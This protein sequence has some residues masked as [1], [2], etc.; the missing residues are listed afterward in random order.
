MGIK[1]K[2]FAVARSGKYKMKI[3][4]VDEHGIVVQ[5]LRGYDQN[6]MVCEGYSFYEKI[7]NKEEFNALRWAICEDNVDFIFSDLNCLIGQEFVKFVCLEQRLNK[8]NDSVYFGNGIDW[9]NYLGT[10]TI[11]PTLDCFMLK[12]GYV[13]KWLDDTILKDVTTEEQ[14]EMYSTLKLKYPAHEIH[15]E[16]PVFMSETI[17]QRADIIDY[18]TQSIFEIDGGQHESNIVFVE[19]DMRKRFNARKNGFTIFHCPNTN[20]KHI[21]NLL[22]HD[23]YDVAFDELK[24][25]NQKLMQNQVKLLASGFYE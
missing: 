13:N 5:I 16:A 2:K 19:N 11:M 21:V 24:A 4:D 12:Y 7:N 17:P 6:T 18:T 23:K 1:D 25:Y 8:T 3:T 22:K 9:F 14:W 10:P 15:C 20:S